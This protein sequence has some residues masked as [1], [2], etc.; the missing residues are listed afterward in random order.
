MRN[1]RTV[2]SAL[3][4]CGA[5]PLFA[6]SPPAPAPTAQHESVVVTGTFDPVSIEEMDRAVTS[7]P[8]RRDEI[9][10]N[11]WIDVLRDEP[12]VD[13]Q[14]RAPGGV[15]SDVSI[16]GGTFGQTL[17]LL[18]GIRLNDVQS[19]HHDMDLPVPLSAIDHVEV[20]RG[21][22]SALYGSDA[23]GGVI[24]VIT[25]APE[26][27]ELLLRTAV[28]SFGTNEQSGS[29][30]VAGNRAVEQITFS[31]D[32]STGFRFDRD[33]R[34]L[35]FGSQTSLTSALGATDIL[36]AYADKPFG[37]DQFYGNYPSW[38][39]TKTWFAAVKQELGP[40]TEALFSYRRHS[41]LF[42]LFRDQPQI[43]TNHHSDESYEA[44]LRRTE[45]LSTVVKL[46][47]GAEFEQ[48]SVVSTNLGDHARTRGS[49]YASL[50]TRHWK[51]FSLS[52]GGREDLYDSSGGQFNPNIA[53]GYWLTSRVRLRGGVSRAFRLPTYTDLYYHD[54]ADLGNA[55]LKPEHAWSYEGGLEWQIASSWRAE[56]TVFQRRDYNGIDYVR[57]S[58]N[59]VWQATNFDRLRFTGVEA[60]LVA[61]LPKHQEMDLRYTGIHGA[62]DSLAGLYSKYAFN[63]PE[64]SGVLEYRAA[65]GTLLLRSRVGVEKRIMRDPYAVWDVYSAWTRWRVR[66]FVQLTN[67]TNANYQEI[68]GIA[69]PGR[70]AL[71]G[72][73][74]QAWR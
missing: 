72:V 9:L 63:F 4:L 73:E 57:A 34:D 66:P 60:A 38:E 17:V 71:G 59:D 36:A 12:S 23:I 3:F 56:A 40:N 69:L 50:D 43:Y 58:L 67:L 13:L 10:L 30:T 46:H 22:G 37:A 25:R 19:G 14:E 16:R 52:L 44:A 28:G 5:G 55:L 27:S 42:V 68:F 54:P 70:A 62:S 26:T 18:D 39:N 31:R 51:R 1:V 53:A 8:V 32:F 20:L 47:Y 49:V 29:L 65:L 21:T 11:S 64:H 41:D 6:Q 15:Q 33:Y 2:C 24:N 61:R 7:L 45:T 48:E 74:I 35:S